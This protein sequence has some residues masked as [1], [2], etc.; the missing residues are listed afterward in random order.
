MD[1]LRVLL[2]EAHRF[3]TFT[4]QGFKPCSE[5]LSRPFL[6]PA[7]SLKLVKLDLLPDTPSRSFAIV[8]PNILDSNVV[9][10]LETLTLTNFPFIPLQSM[11]FPGIRTL[12]IES[13]VNPPSSDDWA[14]ALTAMPLLG[15]LI[16]VSAVL[17]RPALTP[18]STIQVF[19]RHLKLL[20]FTA[21]ND[22]DTGEVALL[23]QLDIPED[24]VISFI[25]EADV[26]LLHHSQHIIDTILP[27]ISRTDQKRVPVTLR[28]R[29]LEGR[30]RV[31]L[32]DFGSASRLLPNGLLRY[33]DGSWSQ[34]HL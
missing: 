13:P 16:L 29:E 3:S 6:R 15:E 17:P 23:E 14:S 26:P 5:L 2:P 33:G 19:L 11:R 18:A 31:T 1:A 7:L 8:C 12:Q 4:L 28:I 9:P 25:S 21:L 34:C 32:W 10:S 20:R 22:E 30:I 24:T 27:K